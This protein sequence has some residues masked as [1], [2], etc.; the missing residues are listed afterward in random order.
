MKQPIAKERAKEKKRG[1]RKWLAGKRFAH[2]HASCSALQNDVCSLSTRTHDGRDGLGSAAGCASA[3]GLDDANA[4]WWGESG[5][6]V[7]VD[8]EPAHE[9][10]ALELSANTESSGHTLAA[11]RIG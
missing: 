2:A 1:E 6:V 3:R 11:M 8:A 7:R 4:G 9:D 10:M 5:G